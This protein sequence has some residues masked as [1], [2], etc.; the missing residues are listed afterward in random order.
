VMVKPINR[1]LHEPGYKRASVVPGGLK[2]TYPGYRIKVR[3]YGDGKPRNPWPGLR[4]LP[5]Y[6]FIFRDDSLQKMFTVMDKGQVVNDGNM[7]ERLNLFPLHDLADGNTSGVVIDAFSIFDA[8]SPVSA[9]IGLTVDSDDALAFSGEVEKAIKIEAKYRVVLSPCKDDLCYIHDILA[10][11][12]VQARSHE[13]TNNHLAIYSRLQEE[14][15]ESIELLQTRMEKDEEF[16]ASKLAQID[17][18]K[19]MMNKVA[20]EDARFV[21]AARAHMGSDILDFIWKMV[22]DWCSNDYVGERLSDEQIWIVD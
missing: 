6:A 18:F 19:A 13:L 2:V 7:E 16:Q 15:G 10:K 22:P 3:E 21:K 11:C 12:A 17:Y 4:R 9:I 1:F 14:S 8:K 20:Q 5:E